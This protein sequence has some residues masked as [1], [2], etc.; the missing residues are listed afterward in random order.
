MASETEVPKI[1]GSLPDQ[2]YV[3]DRVADV[4]RGDLFDPETDIL[5][6]WS[7]T[8]VFTDTAEIGYAR[9]YQVS[10]AKLSTRASSG[11]SALRVLSSNRAR[12]PVS[13]RV[14]STYRHP[15]RQGEIL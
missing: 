7:E 4:T 15:C 12:Q 13:G 1:A 2:P 11:T 3:D 10:A 8:P 5:S 14:G 9:P 6:P